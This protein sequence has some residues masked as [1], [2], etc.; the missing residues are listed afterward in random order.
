MSTDVLKLHVWSPLKSD[1]K[2]WLKRLSLPQNGIFKRCPPFYLHIKINPQI[3]IQDFFLSAGSVGEISTCSF[4]F[5]AFKDPVHLQRQ[6]SNGLWRVFPRQRYWADYIPPSGTHLDL[7]PSGIA[8]P[9]LRHAPHGG[10][11]ASPAAVCTWKRGPAGQQ[12]L[13]D[14]LILQTGLPSVLPALQH[15]LLEHVLLIQHQI[16]N[17]S[18]LSAAEEIPHLDRG[19]KRLHWNGSRLEGPQLHPA[20][21]LCRR[22]EIKTLEDPQP[23]YELCNCAFISSEGLQILRVRLFLFGRFVHVSFLFVRHRKGHI[24]ICYW[25]MISLSIP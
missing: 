9:K 6:S 12:Q 1:L 22:A 2:K 14:R 5:F 18:S 24:N 17:K 10:D 15:H 23:E 25:Y 20:D 21:V 3:V 13:H 4:P 16:L 11:S 19:P 8:N 7:W